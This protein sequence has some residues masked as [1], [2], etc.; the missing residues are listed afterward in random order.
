M[1]TL[2]TVLVFGGSGLTGASI[3]AALLEREEFEV[4]VPVRPSSINK[5]STIE[6]QKK[7]AT[8]LPFD[9]ASSSSDVLQ[10]FVSGADTII[11]AIVFTQLS[12][13][14]KLI[15]A[16]KS[17]GVERFVPCDF[18]TPGRRGV[19]KLHD[20]KLDVREYVKA[21]GI[22]YTFIDVGFWYQLHLMYTDVKKAYVP[23][24][25]EAS[26]Y[27]YNGGVVKTAYTD[28]ADIGKFV[29]RIVTD[30][31]TLNQYVFAWGEEIT[32][33]DLLKYAQKYGNPNVEIFP[34]STTDLESLIAEA[35]EKKLGTL[36]YWDYHY[37]MWV[38]GENTVEMAKLPELGGA[39]DTR[40][41]YPDMEVRPLEDYAIEFYR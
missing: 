20:Q 33:Q 15:D 23:W 17:A 4:K 2:P 31:R 8:I 19:R 22:G 9:I 35:K 32:Q 11:C 25:Y 30:P 10:E 26:R 16:A 6:L 12:L 37:S 13:Q 36:A 14:Y 29:A 34:K 1:S 5:P 3:V 28:L 18:G 40:E 24:L 7:G 38:L 21:S 41:L 39:L 27:V